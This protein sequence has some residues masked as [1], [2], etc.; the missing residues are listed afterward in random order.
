MRRS[1]TTHH[2]VPRRIAIVGGGVSG[3]ARRRRA[4]PRRSRDHRLRGRRL[5][6]R[7]HE[8]DRRSR[9]RAAAR[10][11]DTG[12]IVMNDRNYPNFEAILAELGVATQRDEHEL[13][14]LRRPRRL[15]VGGARHPRHLRPPRHTCR[16]AASS[17]CWPTS[18]ASTARRAPCSASDG[19]GPRC[20]S[21]STTAATPSTSSSA[22]SS[23]RPPR[24]GRPIPNRCGASRPRS[25]PRSST[26]TASCSSAA[27]RAGARSSAARRR[28]VEALTAP[29]ADRIRLR[30]PVGEVARDDG[31]RLDLGRR[32][33]RALRRGR[34]RH[35]LRPGAGDARP[36]R[37]RR[38][39]KCSARSP[40]S[41]NEAVL[42]TDTSLMPR[43][44]APGRAGTTTS[45]A[46]PSDGRTTADL[47]HEPPAVA[48]DRGPQFLV[49]LNRT[50]AIDPGEDHQVIDYAHPVFTNE[51]MSAQARW[52]RDQR[53][54]P[55]PLLRRLLALGLPRG[56]RLV[57]PARLRGARRP[58]T[59]PR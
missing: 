2:P 16:P 40:T 48:R 49:T 21:S 20:A 46:T 51:G 27:V 8:H 29:F 5:R 12:F 13:R 23:P 30:S 7:A 58:R 56:R 18:S 44:R 25:S 59:G 36:S 28:Y 15:R 19:S 11:V 39:A 57:R 6:R 54:R 55:D 50:E 52:A 9:P 26:T 17:A 22:C 47:R 38:S 10:D 4:A 24:S 34:D 3:P 53:R 33:A 41:A 31:R 35:P 42:H 37:P 32:R 14:R 45:T 43:R 1:L